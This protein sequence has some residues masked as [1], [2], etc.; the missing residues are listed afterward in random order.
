MEMWSRENFWSIDSLAEP[1]EVRQVDP[2]SAKC[3]RDGAFIGS[4]CGHNQIRR[5]ALRAIALV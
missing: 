4:L 1:R 3:M 2:R 5:N